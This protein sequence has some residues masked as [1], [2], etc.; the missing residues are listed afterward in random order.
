MSFRSRRYT[1]LFTAKPS[2]KMKDK[3]GRC[4]YGRYGGEKHKITRM[5]MMSY[6]ILPS[7][8]SPKQMH[9]LKMAEGHLFLFIVRWERQ[10]QRLGGWQP[11]QLTYV[12]CK[13][14]SPGIGAPNRGSRIK[15][16]SIVLNRQL[17]SW[18]L[19]KCCCLLSLLSGNK[20]ICQTVIEEKLFLIHPLAS[21]RPS[22][23]TR[24]TSCHSRK[25]VS[26]TKT[27]NCLNS[28]A[29][30]HLSVRPWTQPAREI[31]STV[32]PP[33]KEKQTWQGSIYILWYGTQYLYLLSENSGERGPLYS[34]SPDCFFSFLYSFLTKCYQ[35][36][37][38]RLP[39]SMNHRSTCSWKACV[40][41]SDTQTYTQSGVSV[42]NPVRY[43]GSEWLQAL[44]STTVRGG[45]HKL[46]CCVR[47][48]NKTR[49][50]SSKHP[51][52]L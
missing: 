23:C 32:I 6:E 38:C 50:R 15:E 1:T 25:C 7:Q 5:E 14:V 37:L 46:D 3:A 44:D 34:D 2:D 43:Q 20:A 51:L 13:A 45:W 39:S 36:H 31:Q 12:Y 24:K 48:Q 4:K 47:W 49:C 40:L 9:R 42:W 16:D 21:E 22:R 30:R 27:C 18:E 29:R 35:Q 33:R 19:A 10:Q 52:Q 17:G 11:R 41:L 28:A 8:Q 26:K